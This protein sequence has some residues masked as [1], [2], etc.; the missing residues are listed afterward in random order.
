[1]T[2]GL[3]D[4]AAFL[5]IALA[6]SLSA[7]SKPPVR[8]DGPTAGAGHAT[9]DAI[10]AFAAR[11]WRI[12]S[13]TL[14]AVHKSNSTTSGDQGILAI[15]GDRFLILGPNAQVDDQGRFEPRG[16][17]HLR[18]RN[19]SAVMEL[20]LQQ[21]T[22]AEAT[23]EGTVDFGGTDAPVRFV[24]A[25][26]ST[27]PALPSPDNMHSAAALG[28]APAIG[29]L[30]AAGKRVDDGKGGMTP[31]MVAAGSCHPAAVRKLLDSG[32]DVNA[33]SADGKTALIFA[34]ECGDLDTVNALIAKK[35]TVRVRRRDDQQTP[36][37]IA[38][39][40]GRLDLVRALF[41]AGAD[42]SDKD[43][44]GNGL[45]S[46]ASKGVGLGNREAPD[47]IAFLL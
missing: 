1:M 17:R 19:L 41:A 9:T 28:D 40:E 7:C 44:Y 4:M 43:Q 35:A 12:T 23:L 2:A 32:A 24:L 21:S 47:L 16:G 3:R 26:M 13:T 46:V 15:D 29:R 10:N 45:L 38:V 11:S 14:R 27:A 30:L 8:A 37:L 31:L 6:A 42:A 33:V 5:M 18:F 22:S 20:E 39:D 36:L 25:A 34:T